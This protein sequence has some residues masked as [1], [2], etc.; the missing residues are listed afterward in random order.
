MSTQRE[1]TAGWLA[2]GL[3]PRGGV[4][5]LGVRLLC[6]PPIARAEHP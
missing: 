3:E 6:P 1:G 5:S 4:D 2:T